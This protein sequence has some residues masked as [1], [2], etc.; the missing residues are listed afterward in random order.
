MRNKGIDV[1]YRNE[2]PDPAVV[3]PL[4]EFNLVEIARSLV[5]DRRPEEMAHLAGGG[6]W[7]RGKVRLAKELDL[8]P[9]CVREVGGKAVGDHCIASSGP[10][11]VHSGEWG[12]GG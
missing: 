3:A 2:Q 1:R 5:V 6:R 4:G 11:I 9:D 12:V 8:F 10:K 7:S